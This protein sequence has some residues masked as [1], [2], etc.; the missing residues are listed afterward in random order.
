MYMRLCVLDQE[1]II[2]T[3]FISSRL[4]LT[5][6]DVI[7]SQLMMSD[8]SLHSMMLNHTPSAPEIAIHKFNNQN[9]LNVKCA[10]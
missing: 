7:A 1:L 5:S 3:P 4:N 8:I 10:L 6:V 9:T 2:K